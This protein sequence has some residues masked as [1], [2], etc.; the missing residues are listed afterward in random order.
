MADYNDVAPTKGLFWLAIKWAAFIAV[1]L[2]AF[3][4]LLLPLLVS[5]KLVGREA[6]K[7]DAETSAQ[8]YDNSR[9]FQQGVNRDIARYCRDWATAEGPARKAVADLILTTRD[10][11]QGDLT[12]SNASCIA[13]IEGF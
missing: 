7:F 4:F 2:L 3:Y 13:Q 10:T 8:V 9:Q 12:P 5:G 11:Y 1:L 6:R